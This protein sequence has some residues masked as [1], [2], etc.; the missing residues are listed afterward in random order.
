MNFS[1]LSIIRNVKSDYQTVVI[2]ITLLCVIFHNP[3]LVSDILTDNSVFSPFF[4]S[5][6]LY[7]YIACR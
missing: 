6:I 1:D 5:S 3:A 7:Y 4:D 2:K